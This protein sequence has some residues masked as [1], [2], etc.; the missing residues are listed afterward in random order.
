MIFP[1]SVENNTVLQKHQENACKNT[2]VKTKRQTETPCNL[3][4]TEAWVNPRK[5]IFQPKMAVL[6]G[7]NGQEF[8]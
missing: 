2:G 6:P 1:I 7:S 4:S 3:L 8:N 5:S